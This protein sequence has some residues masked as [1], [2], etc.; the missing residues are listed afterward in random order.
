M[1]SSYFFEWTCFYGFWKMNI[2]KIMSMCTAIANNSN[3][4][5]LIFKDFKIRYVISESYFIT[6]LLFF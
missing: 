5:H 3:N 2:E 4:L 6:Q 1:I